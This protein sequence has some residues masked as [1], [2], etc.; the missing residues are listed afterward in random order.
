MG[1]IV[2]LEGKQFGR[3]AVIRRDGT[4]STG[5]ITWFCRCSCGTIRSVRGRSLTAGTTKSCGC[6]QKEIVSRANF[7]HGHGGYMR[8]REYKSWH[9]MIQRCTN[10]RNDRWADYGGRGITVC[11]RWLVFANFLSD[12]GK[13]PARKSIDRKDND[14]GYNP[15]NCRWATPHEQQLN[16]RKRHQIQAD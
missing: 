8:S 7:K 13:R 1:I 3:L 16:R 6:L 14:S 11:K 15:G 5:N 10:S 9:M 4:D 2:H 12:M